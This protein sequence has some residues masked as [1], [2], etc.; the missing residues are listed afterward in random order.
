[1]GAG[2]TGVGLQRHHPVAVKAL[3]VSVS[4]S[5][6]LVGPR[7]FLPLEDVKGLDAQLNLLD[8]VRSARVLL[9]LTSRLKTCLACSRR[10]S[11]RGD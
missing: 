9:P 5:Q 11:E 10:P 3:P 2:A 8:R 7:L 6:P 1:V 4:S